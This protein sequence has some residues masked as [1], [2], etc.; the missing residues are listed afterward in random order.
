MSRHLP[1]YGSLGL[2]LLV[3]SPSSCFL[4]VF[5]GPAAAVS[6][7]DTCARTAR[8]PA[9]HRRRGLAA[10]RNWR[11][12]HG[13]DDGDAAL[14]LAAAAGEEAEEEDR[15]MAAAVTAAMAGGKARSNN[16][17]EPRAV[18]TVEAE[19]I[20][21]VWVAVYILLCRKRRGGDEERR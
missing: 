2:Y 19:R 17:G 14:A 11:C 1:T 18:A 5:A 10:D 16:G 21:S 12:L 8:A 7:V 20:G 3:T 4:D 15:E 13:D 9:R 6:V